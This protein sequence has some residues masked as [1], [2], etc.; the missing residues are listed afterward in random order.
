V[1]GPLT[2]KTERGEAVGSKPLACDSV[3]RLFSVQDFTVSHMRAYG[4]PPPNAAV[5]APRISDKAPQSI[6]W[7]NA[8]AV[9]IYRDARCL[10]RLLDRLGCL[11]PAHLRACHYRID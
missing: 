1:R 2:V 8:S 4:A 5:I 3:G 10:L 11:G 7:A 9:L 6:T